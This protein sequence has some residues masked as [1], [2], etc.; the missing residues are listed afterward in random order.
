MHKDG[1]RRAIWPDS[2][3]LVTSIS[4]SG[5]VSAYTW[6]RR[7]HIRSDLSEITRNP[8]TTLYH[9][10]YEPCSD[11]A[12]LPYSN[13][14]DGYFWRANEM[15]F[16][17]Y[18]NVIKDG[19]AYLFGQANGMTAVARVLVGS[20]EVKSQYEYWVNGEWTRSKPSIND[21][22]IDIP[23]ANAGGQGTY[24][25]SEPWQSFVWIG[26]SIFP[27]AEYVHHYCT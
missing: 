13:V 23:N 16:G 26:G 7:T 25:Y 18:G 4:E 27:G 20:I 8:A 24:Y 2:P 15:P 1:S 14:V 10:R 11:K 9:I 12:A 6:V 21:R 22:S 5:K 3:P 19:I 17:V